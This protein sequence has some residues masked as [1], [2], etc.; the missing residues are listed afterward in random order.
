MAALE[1]AGE[2]IDPPPPR[3]ARPLL[4]GA[5]AARLLRRGVASARLP[6]L[7]AALERAVLVRDRVVAAGLA[8]AAGRALAG[9]ATGVGAGVA[10]GAAG[11]LAGFGVV[12]GVAA[13]LAGA[14]DPLGVELAM[15]GGREGAANEGTGRLPA[16]LGWLAV[17]RRAPRSR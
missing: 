15:A 17:S 4:A 5:W 14:G 9:A 11:V 1:E 13:E 12:A 16:R 3:P 2:V 7:R 10:A 6:L 8:V